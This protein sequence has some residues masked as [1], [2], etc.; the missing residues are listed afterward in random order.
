MAKIVS[1]VEVWKC[2]KCGAEQHV[3]LL[4]SPPLPY[5]GKGGRMITTIA[6]VDARTEGWRRTEAGELCPQCSNTRAS[7]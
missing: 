4:G 1:S 5:Q 3:E 6:V 7:P 2:H